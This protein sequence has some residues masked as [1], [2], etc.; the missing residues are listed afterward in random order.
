MASHPQTIKDGGRIMMLW[1]GF[2][3]SG[4]GSLAKDERFMNT[5]KHGGFWG[6]T[7]SIWVVASS[8]TV[9]TTLNVSLGDQLS[10]ED[11]GQ[12]SL[13]I[14][15][16]LESSWK[17]G[18]NWRKMPM[19]ED[20][21]IWRNSRE[22]WGR[23]SSKEVSETWLKLQQMTVS[24][25]ILSQIVFVFCWILFIFISVCKNKIM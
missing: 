18:V 22:E 3:A 9:T 25:I 21:R 17:Y 15:V 7:C 11:Q 12:W 19:P 20:H 24:G 1:G 10:P 5:D 4:T 6:E 13:E 2:S 16:W 8:F 14:V 23:D